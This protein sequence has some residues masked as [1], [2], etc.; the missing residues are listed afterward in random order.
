[1]RWFARFVARGAFGALWMLG[2]E[3]RSKFLVALPFVLLFYFGQG[4]AGRYA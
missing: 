3:V 1:L 2:A 4:V